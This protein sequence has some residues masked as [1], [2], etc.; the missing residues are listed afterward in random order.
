MKEK[1][2]NNNKNKQDFWF[3]FF[4]LTSNCGFVMSLIVQYNTIWVQWNPW[5]RPHLLEDISFSQTF[6]FI[7]SC[8]LDTEPTPVSL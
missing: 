4:G 5:W 6:S 1:N 2:E 8:K 7:V 3:Y